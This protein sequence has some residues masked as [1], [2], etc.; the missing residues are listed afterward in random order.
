[1][2]LGFTIYYNAQFYYPAMEVAPISIIF[3]FVHL[4]LIGSIHATITENRW[5]SLPADIETVRAIDNTEMTTLNEHVC[6]ALAS[7]L[8]DS[9][10]YCFDDNN[11]VIAH[12]SLSAIAIQSY[13]NIDYACKTTNGKLL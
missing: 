1:M 12:G 8:S 13:P 5:K 9:E 4:I 10:L 2:Y 7:S 3:I 11:C 6:A